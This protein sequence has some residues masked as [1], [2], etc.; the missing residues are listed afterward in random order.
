MSQTS[1]GLREDGQDGHALLGVG[2]FVRFFSLIMGSADYVVF[3]TAGYANAF[4]VCAVMW[5]SMMGN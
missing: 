4:G 3:A 1:L 5:L 2:L